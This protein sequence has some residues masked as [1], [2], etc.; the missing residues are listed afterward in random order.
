MMVT[1]LAWMA[2]RLVSVNKD[3]CMPRND[4]SLY[5]CSRSCHVRHWPERSLVM[6]SSPPSDLHSQ[7]M[8]SSHGSR[9]HPRN[10]GG[11]QPWVH[12][13]LRWTLHSTGWRNYNLRHLA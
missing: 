13:H 6:C 4:L 1:R 7:F 12:L 3:T 2:S 5:L 10:Q 8:M 11:L 9:L